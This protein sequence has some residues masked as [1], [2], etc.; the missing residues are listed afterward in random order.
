MIAPRIFRQEAFSE[1]V[2]VVL[3]ETVE[4]S[5]FEASIESIEPREADYKLIFD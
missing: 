4:R 5:G 3:I 2:S 1:R